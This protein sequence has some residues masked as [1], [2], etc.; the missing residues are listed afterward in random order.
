MKTKKEYLD[1][2][3]EIIVRKLAP[4]EGGGYFAYYKDYK[5]IMGDGENM[6]EAM[7]DVKSAFGCYLEV[8]LEKGEA[9]KEPSHLNRSKRINITIPVSVLNKIDAY[10]KSHSLTRSSFFKESALQSMR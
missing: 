3:Y 1:M 9:I 10:V 4:E 7:D 6:Q 8:A 5:G 2:D